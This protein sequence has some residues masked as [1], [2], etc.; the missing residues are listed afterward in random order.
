MLT[1]GTGQDMWLSLDKTWPAHTRDKFPTH[2]ST[3]EEWKRE[4]SAA[5]V[6]LMLL[7]QDFPYQD[8]LLNSLD[9]LVLVAWTAAW[10]C[11]RMYQGIGT[12]HQQVTDRAK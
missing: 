12:Y 10:R 3:T 9:E 1:N 6:T 2:Q 5:P 8:S 7:L 4:V 11:D